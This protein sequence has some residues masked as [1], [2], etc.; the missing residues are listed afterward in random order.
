MVM[1]EKKDIKSY[2]LDELKQE[3]AN[4][5]EKPLEQDKYINGYILKRFSLL[6]K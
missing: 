2:N 4:M 3:L 1:T 6:M 5:G